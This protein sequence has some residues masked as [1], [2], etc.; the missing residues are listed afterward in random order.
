L[1]HL[2]ADPIGAPQVTCVQ[3]D[4]S[5]TFTFVGPDPDGYQISAEAEGFRP[6]TLAKGPPWSCGLESL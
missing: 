6:G 3:T 4:A 2:V 1:S 5:D